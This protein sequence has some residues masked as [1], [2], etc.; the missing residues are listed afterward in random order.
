MTGNLAHVLQGISEKDQVTDKGIPQ[1]VGRC[2]NPS[3]LHEELD[4]VA[5]IVRRKGKGVILVIRLLVMF[6]FP[7]GLAPQLNFR[8]LGPESKRL[9][10]GSPEYF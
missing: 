2:F 5:D 6:L 10:E 8:L 3:L 7:I 9:N 4:L 1:I